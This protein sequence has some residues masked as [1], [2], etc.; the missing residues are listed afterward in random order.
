MNTS[1]DPSS[2]PKIGPFTGCSRK[3]RQIYKQIRKAASINISILLQGETGT[4]KDLAAWTIHCLSDRSDGPY[5]PC[6]EDELRPEHFPAKLR[7][8][9][10]PSTLPEIS[11]KIGTPLQEVECALIQHILEVVN[12]NRTEAAKL[13]GI[14]RRALYNRLHKHQ[15]A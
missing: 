13:L 15:I 8:A 6:D 10:T 4:G 3:M 12:N 7:T 1:I 5:I 9:E 2:I 14:S 11:F